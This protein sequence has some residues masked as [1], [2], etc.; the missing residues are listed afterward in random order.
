ML[1]N[2]LLIE[3]VSASK[4]RVKKSYLPTLSIGIFAFWL[5]RLVTFT[6]LEKKKKKEREKG[7]RNERLVVYPPAALTSL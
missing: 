4:G 5:V 1:K 2:D 6:H 7:K 3:L